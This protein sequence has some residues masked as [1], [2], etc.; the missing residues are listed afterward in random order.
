MWTVASKREKI[1][2]SNKLQMITKHV[3]EHWFLSRDFLLINEIIMFSS[4]YI[5]QA[6]V[7]SG[8]AK[9]KIILTR[10]RWQR[11]CKMCFAVNIFHNLVSEI[12]FRKEP[13]YG[14]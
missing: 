4:R 14:W 7:K 3:M 9:I 11:I 1:I 6:Y 8:W 12:F 2:W 13:V 10:Y 5:E